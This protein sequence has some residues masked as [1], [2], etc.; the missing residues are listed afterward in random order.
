MSKSIVLHQS[1]LD[2]L[3]AWLAPGREQAGEKYEFIRHRLLRYFEGR[4]CVPPDEY[5]DETIDRVARRVAAGEQIKSPDPFRYFY[6]VARN[7]C[8]EGRKHQP[9]VQRVSEA[10][11]AVDLASP[12]ELS[13]WKTCWAALTPREQELLEAYYLDVREE[14]VA[15][16]GITPNALRLRVFK[17]KR[18]LRACIS[19]CLHCEQQ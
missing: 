17:V 6:G 4:H 2:A 13:Y 19:C 18:K 15:R 5:V 7:V 10:M 12:P 11:A 3:L 9:F 14:L 8:L 1:D 16:E